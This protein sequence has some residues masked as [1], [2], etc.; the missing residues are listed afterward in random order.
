MTMKVLIHCDAPNLIRRAC[1]SASLLFD[2]ITQEISGKMQEFQ[3]KVNE[4]QK[5]QEADSEA[6]SVSHISAS[7]C[8]FV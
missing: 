1:W 8:W 5:E 6:D 2:I 4:E 7:W 3:C